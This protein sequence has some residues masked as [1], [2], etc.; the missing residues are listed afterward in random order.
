[1]ERKAGPGHARGHRA[2]QKER[3]PAVESFRAEQPEHHN[4]SRADPHQAQHDMHESE[5][6]PSALR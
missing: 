6:R 1:M 5:C 4:E 2:R 3:S